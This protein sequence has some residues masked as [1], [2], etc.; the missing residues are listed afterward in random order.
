MLTDDWNN[1]ENVPW[2]IL[3]VLNQFSSTSPPEKLILYYKV[4][5]IRVIAFL[6]R[7]SSAS[8]V[9]AISSLLNCHKH[10][11]PQQHLTITFCNEII[12]KL[13]FL[14]CN[15]IPVVTDINNI[16]VPLLYHIWT[17]SPEETVNASLH[18]LFEVLSNE[19]E[20]RDKSPSLCLA[21]VLDAIPTKFGEPSLRHLIS[22]RNIGDSTHEL[23]LRR[24][25]KYP[26]WPSSQKATTWIR[27]YMSYL[28]ESGKV[29]LVKSTVEKELEAVRCKST[30]VHK[31][32]AILF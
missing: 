31:I 5:Q 7:N 18:N 17:R 12:H 8:V 16:V 29:E 20:G 21:A 4:C 3:E 22:N 14:V 32:Y 6:S 30:Q 26:T 15:D 28:Y 1:P 2:I 23:I 9:I 13:S 19:E 27:L 10:C 25:C 11:I 24:M